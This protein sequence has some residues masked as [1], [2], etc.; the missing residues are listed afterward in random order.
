MS[1]QGAA[2]ERTENRVKEPKQYNVIMI[3]DDF[4]TME[5]VVDVL[6]TIFHKDEVTAQAI[7][8]NVHKNGQAVVGKYPYD[9]A[10]TRVKKALTRAKEEGFPFRMVI[11]EA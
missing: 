4:T 5:F 7:M 8:M 11:E 1:T 6:V 9:M 10:A 3:N 2:K